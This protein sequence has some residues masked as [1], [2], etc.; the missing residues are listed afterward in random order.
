[1]GLARDRWL[2][3]LCFYQEDKLMM[4]PY[5]YFGVRI[6][7]VGTFLASFF[8]LP[9]LWA[10]FAILINFAITPLSAAL[11]Y[12][13]PVDRDKPFINIAAGMMEF[14]SVLII[15]YLVSLWFQVPNLFLSIVVI[16]YFIN[17]LNR[18]FKSPLHQPVRTEAREL[19]GYFSAW[20]IWQVIY[21][22][23]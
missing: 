19:L 5:I 23:V 16:E 4:I 10:L 11:P 20:A 6:M 2:A 3:A 8:F 17:Q 9:F 7:W 22:F 15:Y 14:I 13:R 1:M 12:Y 21:F 18:V